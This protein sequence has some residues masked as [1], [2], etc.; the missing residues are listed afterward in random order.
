MTHQPPVPPPGYWDYPQAP[1]PAPPQ[2]KT[3]VSL[4]VVVLGIVG[5]VMSMQSTSLL[6]GTGT[7]W[8]G[9]AL[10]AAALAASFFL[11]GATWARVVAAIML[12]L[13]LFSAFYM[14]DQMNKKRAEITQMFDSSYN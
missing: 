1:P 5:L 14:E 8:L 12:A 6:N 2:K 10:V 3:G 4:G 13:A 7:I 9:V 11:G